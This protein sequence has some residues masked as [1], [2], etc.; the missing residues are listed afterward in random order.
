MVSCYIFSTCCFPLSFSTSLPCLDFLVS[1]SSLFSSFSNFLTCFHVQSAARYHIFPFRLSRLLSCSP[2]LCCFLLFRLSCLDSISYSATLHHIS[3]FRV[4][5]LLLF[6][7]FFIFGFLNLYLFLSMLLF[8]VFFSYDFILLIRFLNQIFFVFSFFA[9]FSFFWCISSLF[10]FLFFYFCFSR[11]NCCLFLT[12]SLFILKFC[13]LSFLF[14]LYIIQF[15]SVQ[16]TQRS[17]GWFAI[18]TYYYSGHYVIFCRWLDQQFQ[19][20][21]L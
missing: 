15:E 16:M 13:T 3:L 14:F 17:L 4:S 11:L 18:R 20:R 10:S 12:T 9:F 8:F 2:T 19:T 7:D 6:T 5:F 21:F 1:C